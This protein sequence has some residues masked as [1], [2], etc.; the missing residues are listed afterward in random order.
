MG[1]AIIIPASYKTSPIFAMTGRMGYNFTG[2]YINPSHTYNFE[3]INFDHWR[4]LLEYM[5]HFAVG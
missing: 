2:L 4:E 1:K 5:K 3:C